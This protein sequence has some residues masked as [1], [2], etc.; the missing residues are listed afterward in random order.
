MAYNPCDARDALDKNAQA[1]VRLMLRSAFGGPAGPNSTDRN[2]SVGNVNIDQ[3][4]SSQFAVINQIFSS[5]LM[6]I[7]IDLFLYWY[8]KM[9]L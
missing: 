8:L 3:R 2:W 9:F 4:L 5:Y 7:F 6:Q 1:K